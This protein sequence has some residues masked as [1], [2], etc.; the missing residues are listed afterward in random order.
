M[1][2]INSEDVRYHSSPT[3]SRPIDSKQAIELLSSNPSRTLSSNNETPKIVLSSTWRSRILAV[4][5]Q[6]VPVLITGVVMYLLGATIYWADLGYP[7][8]NSI[9]NALQFASKLHEMTITMSLMAIVL[10]RVNHDLIEASGVALGLLT[11]GYQLGSIT[12]LFSK[13]FWGGLTARSRSKS[14]SWLP[15]WMLILTAFVLAAIVGPASAIV[16]IPSLDWWLVNNP[17]DNGTYSTFIPLSASNIWPI[18]I[19]AHHLDAPSVSTRS[20]GCLASVAYRDPFCPSGGFSDIDSWAKNYMDREAK[21]NITMVDAISGVARYLT[22]STLDENSGWAVSSV[23]G[24][25]QAMD[26]GTFWQYLDVPELELSKIGRPLMRPSLGHA[27]ETKKPIVQAQC[28]WFT[29][30]SSEISF[31]ISHLRGVNQSLMSSGPWII[32][33]DIDMSGPSNRQLTFQWVDMSTYTDEI[34]LLGAVLVSTIP[35]GSIGIIPCT[36]LSHWTPVRIWYD[37][38]A[39]SAVFQDPLDPLSVLLSAP[40]ITTSRNPST[41]LPL[42]PVSITQS[43]A[44][45]LNLPNATTSWDNSHNL[46]LI[47]QSASQFGFLHA[48]LSWRLDPYGPITWLFGTLLSMHVADGLAR[49]NSGYPTIVYQVG[50]VSNLKGGTAGVKG[51]VHDLDDRNVGA[52]NGMP[53]D[54]GKLGENFADLART[55]N[56]SRNTEILWE[57]ERLGYGWGFQIGTTVI[58]GAAVLLAHALIAL[59]HIGVIL[60]TGWGVSRAWASVT[61]LIILAWRSREVAGT[62]LDNTSAG[63]ERTKT[64]RKRVMIRERER[65]VEGESTSAGQLGDGTVVTSRLELILQSDGTEVTNSDVRKVQNGVAYS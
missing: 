60:G 64:W 44:A 40:N 45:S 41:Q 62:E 19:D 37:P 29:N 52:W 46:T 25:R 36:I 13:A 39:G 42:Q 32:P 21:S 9:L 43:W 22:S 3:I 4:L 49:V 58:L 51:T 7:Y 35:N 61:E 6:I 16:M 47:E 15:L 59:I 12:Y 38:K 2:P 27:V 63:I 34:P 10:H 8:Q 5:I 24:L 23:A 53:L 50:D 31:Q 20:Q 57:F 28:G 56:S 11:A 1:R 30:E 18:A 17:L 65:R 26:L 14:S 54:A 55:T 33:K 48:N